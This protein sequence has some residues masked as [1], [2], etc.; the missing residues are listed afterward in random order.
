M[1]VEHISTLY[2]LNILEHILNSCVEHIST[3]EY[4]YYYEYNVETKRKCTQ[5]EQQTLN[6]LQKHGMLSALG[7]TIKV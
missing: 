4:E 5:D 1:H 3:H 6:F 2:I 7:D